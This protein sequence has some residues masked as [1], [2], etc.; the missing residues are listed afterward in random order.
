MIIWSLGPGGAQRQALELA[1]NLKKLGHLVDVYCY[2]HDKNYCHKELCDSLTIFSVKNSDQINNKNTEFLN[3]NFPWWIKIFLRL[4]N[5]TKM[6]KEIFVVDPKVRGLQEFIKK[7]HPF[8]YYDV[9]NI[10][11]WIGKISR[12]IHHPH[13]VWMM[14]DVQRAPYTKSFGFRHLIF[15]ALQRILAAKEIKNISRIVVLDKRNKVLCKSVYNRDSTIVRSGID[16]KMF[17]GM[18]VCRNYTKP[19]L[20]ILASNAFWPHR[21]FEDLVDAIEILVKKNINNFSVTI[22]GDPRIFHWYYRFIQKRIIDKRLE[23]YISINTSVLTENELR[24][25]Y[26]DSDI[27]VFPNNEQTWGLSV[28]EAMLAG[29]ACIVSNGSGA[30]EVLTNGKDSLIVNCCSPEEIASAI[31][32]FLNDRDLMKKISE[33]GILFVKENLSWKKY[34]LQMETIFKEKFSNENLE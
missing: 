34:A 9:I 20:N 7:Q 28:F 22:N 30:H 1:I 12:T 24:K 19:K 23:K 13:I 31:E 5:A 32:A 33:N 17:S 8:N 11:D 14:N 6:V 27:F 16:L 15:N 29:C 25:K 26:L 2:A 21:R 3:S 10:Q 18:P 4:Y